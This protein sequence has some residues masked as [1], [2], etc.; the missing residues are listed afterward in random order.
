MGPS[1]PVLH[2]IL[3]SDANLRG[4][5]LWLENLS[6]GGS[7]MVPLPGYFQKVT[8]SVQEVA[9]GSVTLRTYP[10][11]SGPSIRLVSAVNVG[12]AMNDQ[13]SAFS[14]P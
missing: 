3:W 8:S 10:D 11:G 6:C 4:D 2:T 12:P 1:S 13:A 7:A 9:C 14:Y 5:Q